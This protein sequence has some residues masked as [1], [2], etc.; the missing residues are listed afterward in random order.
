MTFTSSTP[1][2]LWLSSRPK[3]RI[4]S[5]RPQRC[6]GVSPPWIHSF[7]RNP[8]MKTIPAI[9]SPSP[10]RSLTNQGSH[11]RTRTANQ[12]RMEETRGVAKA[13]NKK[14]TKKPTTTYL[15][16]MMTRIMIRRTVR[17]KTI[18]RK[19]PQKRITRTKMTRRDAALGKRKSTPTSKTMRWT[20]AVRRKT[21]AVERMADK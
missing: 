8:L 10:R 1:F 20:G 6:V 13:N 18:E 15:Q 4:P 12:K 19:S 7:P 3:A 2:T 9:K 16:V 17:K 5:V 11:A 14:A 21:N